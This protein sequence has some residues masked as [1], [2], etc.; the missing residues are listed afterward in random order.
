MSLSVWHF[1]LPRIR[2]SKKLPFVFSCEEILLFLSSCEGLRSRAIFS[3][4]YS[5]GLRVSELR[6]MQISHIDSRRM[7][8]LIYQGKGK[9]GPVCSFIG[10]NPVG[11]ARILFQIS[12]QVLS[13]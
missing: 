7:Q 5:C 13:L 10:A 3:L 6:H 2:K 8:V 11:F 1:S 12:A 4:I 9:K